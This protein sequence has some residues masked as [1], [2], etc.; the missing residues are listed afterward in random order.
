MFVCVRAVGDSVETVHSRQVF[1]YRERSIPGRGLHSACI[2]ANRRSGN[3]L[4]GMYVLHVFLQFRLCHRSI[5]T[6]GAP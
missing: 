6:I 5:G 3:N 2:G 1:T 4:H